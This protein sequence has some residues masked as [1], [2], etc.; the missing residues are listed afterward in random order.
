ML[1]QIHV[2]AIMPRSQYG[3]DTDA[4]M[5]INLKVLQGSE[6]NNKPKECN[7]YMNLLNKKHNKKRIWIKNPE[8]YTNDNLQLLQVAL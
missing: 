4:L 2:D 5:T 7:K 3:D 6:L 1:C 8:K